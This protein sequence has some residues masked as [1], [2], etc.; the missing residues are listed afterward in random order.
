MVTSRVVKG[1]IYLLLASLAWGTTFVAQRS[2]MDHL[3]PFSYSGMR[4]LLGSLFLLPLVIHRYRKRRNRP[5]TGLH[6]G[7]WLPLGASV[8]TG[9]L[10][11]I[12]IN[13]QQIG[14]IS[15]TAGKGGF[16]TGLYVVIVPILGIVFGQK[17]GTGV[18][19]GAALA[20]VGLYLL[21]VTSGFSLAPGD[22]W[23]LSCAFV[24][25]FQV[26]S[27]GWLSPKVDSFVLALGQAAVCAFLS[28]TVAVFIEQITYARV[29]AAAF[30]LAYGGIVSV[31]LGYTLQVFGQK[32]S[33]ASHAAIIMQF[34][35]VFAVI[36]GW[37]FL[38]EVLTTRALIGCG[39]MLG[40]MLVSEVVS[41]RKQ[42]GKIIL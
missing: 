19:I 11:F 2:A 1:N 8:L 35:A 24:W 33:K 13:L 38:H 42:E 37:F 34:E 7:K 4:F 27:L 5:I 29:W 39:L 12:G 14:L 16:I 18:W 32:Y 31:G 40:G 3:G 6:G 28:L 15:S 23:I 22:G 9:S 21:S 10:V 26:L 20:T 30:D 25:A 36:S 41:D 17:A